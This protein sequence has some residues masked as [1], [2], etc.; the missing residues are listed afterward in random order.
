MA[1]PGA[2]RNLN[3]WR[4][5]YKKA[6]GAPAWHVRFTCQHVPCHSLL[7]QWIFLLL[8][9]RNGI[10]WSK[11][12]HNCQS[13]L[14]DSSNSQNLLLLP[15]SSILTYRLDHQTW[16]MWFSVKTSSDQTVQ[17]GLG[18]TSHCVL[19]WSLYHFYGA[20]QDCYLAE[21]SMDTPRTFRPEDHLTAC[22]SHLQLQH[23]TSSASALQ[24]PCW[25]SHSSGSCPRSGANDHGPCL[26]SRRPQTCSQWTF[27]SAGC[28]A[29]QVPVWS[30][31]PWRLSFSGSH[32]SGCRWCS[33]HTHPLR[34]S[35]RKEGWCHGL[36]QH[37]A[38]LSAKPA[39]LCK[40]DRHQRLLQS[41]GVL[42][43]I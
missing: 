15:K 3:G 35:P 30:M 39:S 33:C 41:L 4:P 34:L 42:H 40:E 28:W 29:F 12:L 43:H 32:T 21:L 22:L 20:I 11:L 26:L 16:H 27:T 7:S 13:R 9:Q 17:W 8:W 5:R 18:M 38:N 31:P 24:S 23:V 37:K 6:A 36:P 1:F 2:K 14:G 19:R 10:C 25:S